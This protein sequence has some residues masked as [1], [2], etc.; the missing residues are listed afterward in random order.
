[1]ILHE[2]TFKVIRSTHSGY[3]DGS[4]LVV[5]PLEVLWKAK[6][7]VLTVDSGTIT[8]FASIPT[9]FRNVFPVNG[10]HRLAAVAHDALYGAGGRITTDTVIG[11]RGMLIATTEDVEVFYTRQDA[12][13]LFYEM[14]I[15]EGVRKSKAC[16]MYRA[17][18]WF[19][20]SAWEQ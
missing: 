15:C 19:G 10:R 3:I 2:P 17:V 4:F 13:L 11:V 1:M 12:D 8:N 9:G 5:E 6:R 7:C 14:M 20:R 18:R 16:A